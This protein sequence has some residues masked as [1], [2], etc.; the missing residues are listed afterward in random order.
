MK[1]L[2]LLPDASVLSSALV[3]VLVAP[4]AVTLGSLR[5][6]DADGNDDATKQ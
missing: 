6:D 1:V 3:A 5:N 4:R 2:A